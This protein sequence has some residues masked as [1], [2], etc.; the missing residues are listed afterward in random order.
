[1][2]LTANIA[3]RAGIPVTHRGGM[4]LIEAQHAGAFLDACDSEGIRVVGFEGFEFVGDKVKP[5]MDAI[6]DL[7]A[8]HDAATSISEARRIA[9]EVE[10]EGMYLDFT[11][12]TAPTS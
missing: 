8:I 3:A 12:T 10:R 7:G 2:G 5:N 11:L 4:V 1:M 9:D 6:A